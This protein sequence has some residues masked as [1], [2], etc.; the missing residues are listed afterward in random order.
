MWALL[1]SLSLGGEFGL[2]TINP[3]YCG[4]PAVIP[5]VGKLVWITSVTHPFR[6]A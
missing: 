3:F 4:S 2:E 5:S 6:L 1:R